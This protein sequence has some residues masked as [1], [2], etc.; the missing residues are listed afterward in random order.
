MVQLHPGASSRSAADDSADCNPVRLGATPSFDST[1]AS[2]SAGER[3][4]YTQGGGGSIPSL[5]THT[6]LSSNGQDARFSPW[7]PGVST[8]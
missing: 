1:C 5:R 7:K 2:S 6:A 8:P 3:L 4:V